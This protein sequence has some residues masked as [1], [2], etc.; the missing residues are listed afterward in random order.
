VRDRPF[1]R[2]L[3]YDF[4]A[5]GR[6]HPLLARHAHARENNP[7][8]VEL[9]R[10]AVHRFMIQFAMFGRGITT[11]AF[12]CERTAMNP[13]QKMMV[14]AFVCCNGLLADS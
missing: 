11:L 1:N 10:H 14:G 2:D 9:T 5:S 4:H 13:D 8:H 6:A 12:S 7:S 3:L